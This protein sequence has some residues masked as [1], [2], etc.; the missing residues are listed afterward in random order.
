MEVGQ[1]I[2][3]LEKELKNENPRLSA[4][5]TK[6]ADLLFSIKS[7][8]E[9]L[10]DISKIPQSLEFLLLNLSSQASSG[11]LRRLIKS[12]LSTYFIKCKSSKVS[13]FLSELIKVSQS[14]KHSLQSKLTSIDIIGFIFQEFGSKL[15]SPSNE[16]ILD[17]CKKLYKSSDYPGRK[18]ILHSLNRLI[19]SRPTNL[20]QSSNEFLRFYLKSASVKS[21]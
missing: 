20:S 18:L 11:P 12:T 19:A 16:E 17:S 8:V 10:Q 21:P 3:I 7:E 13:G 4:S 14:I 15:V 2:E 1:L 5:N 9:S 6:K